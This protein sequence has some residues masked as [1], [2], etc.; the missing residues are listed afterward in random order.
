MCPDFRTKASRIRKCQLEAGRRK[1]RDT[2]EGDGC[3]PV[4]L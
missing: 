4:R 2:L 1:P 3:L